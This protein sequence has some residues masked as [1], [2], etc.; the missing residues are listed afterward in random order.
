V[1]DLTTGVE[2]LQALFAR[3]IM[4]RVVILEVINDFSFANVHN[5]KLASRRE[6]GAEAEEKNVRISSTIVTD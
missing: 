1:I 4:K 6:S 3:G 2:A 5:Y